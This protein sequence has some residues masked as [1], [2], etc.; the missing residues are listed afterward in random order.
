[1]LKNKLEVKKNLRAL[2]GLMRRQSISQINKDQGGEFVRD[3]E[4][5][6]SNNLLSI[7][8]SKDNLVKYVTEVELDTPSGSYPYMKL[9]NA[10]LT[11]VKELEKSSNLPQVDIIPI[12]YEI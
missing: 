1:M 5:L 11:S 9:L 6:V 12:K 3:K 10:E 8:P 2:D 4:V 7:L